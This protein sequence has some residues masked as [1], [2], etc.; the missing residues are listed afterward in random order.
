MTS[1]WSISRGLGAATNGAMAGFWADI[2]EGGIW[3]VGADEIIADV[4]GADLLYNFGALEITFFSSGSCVNVERKGGG[5]G[6]GGIFDNFDGNETV[7]E[8]C[9]G[10]NRKFDELDGWED[11]R[12][13]SASNLKYIWF[14]LHSLHVFYAIHL[15]RHLIFHIFS[16]GAHY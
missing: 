11:V 5:K 3:T 8:S 2:S 10:T 13:I 14:A 6:G 7:F 16:F 12:R 4:V 9:G 1:N 15:P